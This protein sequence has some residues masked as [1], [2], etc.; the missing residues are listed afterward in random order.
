VPELRRLVGARIM[1]EL[2]DRLGA[3]TVGRGTDD[4]VAAFLHAYRA[5]AVTHPHRYT[6]LP[7]APDTDPELGAAGE[8]AVHTVL[9]VL[10]GYDLTGSDA[11]HATRCLRAAAHGFASLEIA[12]VFGL[13]EDIDETYDRF[14][15]ALTT[16]L[17]VRSAA[18][19]EATR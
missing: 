13:P 6:A 3:A 15:A 18:P 14:I 5:Y 1:G 11:I 2:A 12:G 4:A 19:T 9:A 7:Q 8:R 16:A 10:R 17:T